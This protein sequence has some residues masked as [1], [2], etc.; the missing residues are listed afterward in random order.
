MSVKVVP[1]NSK[2]AVSMEAQ[3]VGATWVVLDRHT[4]LTYSCKFV[5]LFMW[6][7]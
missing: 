5:V 1:C 3:K 4:L 2:G 7:S 6:I